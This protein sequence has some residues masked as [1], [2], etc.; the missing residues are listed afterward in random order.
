[1]AGGTNPSEVV[2]MHTNHGLRTSGTIEFYHMLDD[3]KGSR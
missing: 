1:M 2:K 3:I